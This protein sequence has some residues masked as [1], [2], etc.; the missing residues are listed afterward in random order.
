[1]SREAPTIDELYGAGAERAE[2]VC[3]RRPNTGPYVVTCYDKLTSKYGEAEWHT[4]SDACQF[5]RKK[6]IEGYTV[7]VRFA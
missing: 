5:M 4:W 6:M 3:A 1:M 7:S 2:T